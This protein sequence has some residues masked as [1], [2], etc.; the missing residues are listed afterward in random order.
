MV[1]LFSM[2]EEGRTLVIL[3]ALKEVATQG[4]KV[5]ALSAGLSLLPP[6]FCFSL[7]LLVPL[8]CPL[9]KSSSLL[10]FSV[11]FPLP[12]PPFSIVLFH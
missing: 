10:A 1:S 2:K 3:E 6:S 11:P 7:L 9:T 8:P 5:Y 12:S 4:R